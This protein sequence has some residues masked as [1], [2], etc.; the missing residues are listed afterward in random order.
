MKILASF[1]QILSQFENVLQIRFP[2]L[3]ENFSRWV[4]A[5]FNL[6][7]LQMVKVGCIIQTNFYTKL[8]GM[9]LLPIVIT[10]LV[11]AVAGLHTMCVKEE[12]KR[13]NIVDRAVSLFLVLTYLVFVSVR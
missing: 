5:V 8:V 12:E 3:F 9:T 10:F 13:R 7:A 11:F 2:P 4:G 6:D 1:F